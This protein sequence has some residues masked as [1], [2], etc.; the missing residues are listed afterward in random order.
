MSSLLQRTTGVGRD[1]WGLVGPLAFLLF[2]ITTGIEVGRIGRD[3]YFLTVAGASDIPKMYLFIALIS[4]LLAAGYSVLVPRFEP[5]RILVAILF[6][7]G[8]LSGAV[9]IALMNQWNPP[10]VFP[11]LLFC[12][13]DA[14]IL[15]LL[16][17]FW[18]VANDS[19]SVWEGKQFFP[20]IGAAGM[21]GTVAGGGVTRWVSV[22]FSANSLFV[23]WAALLF[24][25]AVLSTRLATP[26]VETE[27]KPRRSRK[28]EGMLRASWRTPLM[29]TFTY[30]A[31]PMWVMIYI[32]EFSYYEAASRVFVD[33]D[34]LA[35]F[36]GLFVCL[37]SC[38]GLIIQLTVT[39]WLLNRKGV[40]TTAL[41]YPVSITVGAISLLLFSL[42]PYA[43]VGTLDLFG[44]VW[45]VFLARFCDIAIYYSVFDPAAQLMFYAVDSSARAKS[46]AFISGLVFPASIAAAG[47]I[48]LVFRAAH[49]PIHNVSFVAVVLGFLLIVLALNITPE[50][51]K[52]LL[53]NFHPDDERNREQVMKEISRLEKSDIRYV[54]LDS[55]TAT[56][57]DEARFAVEKLL[58]YSDQELYEELQEVLHSLRPEILRMIKARISNE[59]L[60]Q[61]SEFARRLDLQL[62]LLGA[63]AAAIL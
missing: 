31:F 45:L 50:Y 18:A 35:G 1:D 40:G 36:L 21:A 59:D 4:L 57:L 62:A 53:S 23:L 47:G 27:E 34:M 56:D 20:F 19:F 49:E 58:E 13:I 22:Q 5:K 17:H 6:P 29:R 41:F 26:T 51:L 3:S 28:Q 44:V 33:Q 16:M 12:T 32:I 39:R 37:S 63:R 9:G 30:M 38:L 15:F 54:L 61:N 2:L 46:R 43:Q 25:S 7:A 11:Y 10:P 14:Y 8:V 52:A 42:I 48:L 55:I 24:L 60:E